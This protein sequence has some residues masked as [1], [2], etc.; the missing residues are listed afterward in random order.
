M[1]TT[2]RELISISGEPGMRQSPW[3]S[4]DTLAEEMVAVTLGRL[5]SAPKKVKVSL[6]F[7]NPL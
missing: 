1:F 6:S 4:A 7:I 5:T 3:Q 2:F